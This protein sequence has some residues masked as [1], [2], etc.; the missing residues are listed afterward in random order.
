MFYFVKIQNLEDGTSPKAILE[1][2]TFDEAD[3]QFHYDMWYAKTNANNFKAIKCLI[4]NEYGNTV[5]LE[6]WE[7]PASINNAEE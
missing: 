5:K 1:Y 3:A 4:L 7:N 2:A 6:V